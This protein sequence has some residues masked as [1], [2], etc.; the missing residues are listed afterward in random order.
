MCC[1]NRCEMHYNLHINCRTL[2][3]ILPGVPTSCL[4]VWPR[5]WA[6]L[7]LVLS[8]FRGYSSQLGCVCLAYKRY[9]VG[10]KVFGVFGVVRL[11]GASQKPPTEPTSCFASL[12]PK[13]YGPSLRDLINY[14]FP[15]P[16]SVLV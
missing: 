11:S 3:T 15:L 16:T 10:S 6:L 12:P 2:E 7:F 1:L 9:Q 13:R 14:P 5:I 4:Y 8:L